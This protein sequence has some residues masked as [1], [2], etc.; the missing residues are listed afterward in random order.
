M[1]LGLRLLGL[2]EVCNRVSNA[3]L[4][5]ES[6]SAEVGPKGIKAFLILQNQ[7]MECQMPNATSADDAM[8]RTSRCSKR[9]QGTL[10]TGTFDA[11]QFRQHSY[12]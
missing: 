3:A 10:K 2:I 7:I 12:D 6:L 8:S 11:I 5:E 9:C 4:S 1:A